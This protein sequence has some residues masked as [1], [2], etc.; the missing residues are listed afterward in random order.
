[1]TGFGKEAGESLVIH[2]KVARIAFTDGDAGGKAVNVLNPALY[3]LMKKFP[4][5]LDGCPIF[6]V[7]FKISALSSFK[8][9]LFELSKTRRRPNRDGSQRSAPIARMRC[10]HGWFIASEP[11]IQASYLN[12][13]PYSD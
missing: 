8:P 1:L 11:Y 5:S 12:L 9:F 13:S 2:P 4:K 7:Q 6:G 10:L 3:L